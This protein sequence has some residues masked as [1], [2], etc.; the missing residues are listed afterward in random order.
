MY[1]FLEMVWLL[2][3]LKAIRNVILATA[4]TGRSVGVKVGCAVSVGLEDGDTEG[5]SVGT[6]VSVGLEL[7][8][9]D[10]VA[11]GTIETVGSS[12]LVTVGETDGMNEGKPEG[13]ALGAGVGKVVGLAEGA[14]DG[15]SVGLLDVLGGADPKK[16]GLC[17][18]ELVGLDVGIDDGMEVG[19]SVGVALGDAVGDDEGVTVGTS[20]GFSVG[21]SEATTVGAFDSVTEGDDDGTK[22][23]A[24]VGE[25]VGESV[26][27]DAVGDVVGESVGFIVGCMVGF[28]VGFTVGRMV[29]CLVGGED[30]CSV[31]TGIA[32]GEDVGAFELAT[33]LTVALDNVQTLR[34]Y[35]VSVFDG[36]SPGNAPRLKKKPFSSSQQSDP[37][38]DK[39]R[40]DRNLK[41]SR[42]ASGSS[43]KVSTSLTNPSGPSICTNVMYSE[44]SISRF[45]SLSE[46]KRPSKQF[47]LDA[48]CNVSS[49]SAPLSS[50]RYTASDVGASVLLFDAVVSVSAAGV[51]PA[52]AGSVVA[53]SVVNASTLPT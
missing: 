3:S 44:A 27:G 49:A 53:S 47:C 31:A 45:L 8:D 5:A 25:S 28:T 11:E 1:S 14:D 37:S 52:D 43:S 50:K 26:T 12:E 24:L 51:R 29:G 30:G 16:D 18:G 35:S 22:V 13:G 15:F 39:H 19:I 33:W 42:N 38:N 9:A 23:G 6:G 20:L 34:R 4:S 32:V 21:D 41:L 10:G 17:D 40:H 2:P 46:K 36:T 48:D 7:G